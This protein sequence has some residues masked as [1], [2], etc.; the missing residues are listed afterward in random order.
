MNKQ[1]DLA[2]YE[3]ILAKYK[4]IYVTSSVSHNYIVY[5]KLCKHKQTNRINFKNF[6]NKK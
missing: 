1:N 3:K 5:L 2:L 6:M 4:Y